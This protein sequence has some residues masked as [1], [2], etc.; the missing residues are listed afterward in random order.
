MKMKGVTM[1]K[2]TSIVKFYLLMIASLT[3]TFQ[4][5]NDVPGQTEI[6]D[7]SS[8]TAEFSITQSISDQ[9]QRTTLA[10][11]WA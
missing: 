6:V 10:F 2:K 1:M 5:C 11:A 8:S 4:G 7:E 3:L 9:A